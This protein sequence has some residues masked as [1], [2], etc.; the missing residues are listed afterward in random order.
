MIVVHDLHELGRGPDCEPLLGDVE[1]VG[2]LDHDAVR[3]AE[4]LYRTRFDAGAVRE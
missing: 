3:Q 4:E 1:V 2:R